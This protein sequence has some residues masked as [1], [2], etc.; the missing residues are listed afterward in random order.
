MILLLLLQAGYIETNPGSENLNIERALE[1]SK[2]LII[3]GDLNEDQLNPN[4]HNLKNVLLINS[5][6]N[7]INEP[8]RQQALL[9][10]II[11]PEDLPFLDSGTIAV[12]ANISDH[13]ATYIT[14][15][16][17]YDTEG[18]FNRL[19]FLHKRA[20]FTFL[21]QKISNFDWTCLREGTLD[22]A[23]SKFNNTFLNFVNLCVP[24]KNVLI[25]PDD[26]PWYDCEIRRVSRKRDSLKRKFNKSGNHN[27]LARYKCF[28]NK[29]NNLKRHAKEQFYNNLEF[30]ISDF[31]LNDRK[32]FWKVLRHF[33]KGNSSSS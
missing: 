6:S 28:R 22:E 9:D 17:Q 25:R 3:V 18:V 31:H 21:K 32:Q 29:V 23:C 8:T 1:H 2:N 5:M 11:I 7:V 13:K 10:P 15:P 26:K 24:S 27:I 12:P 33:V 20:N 14:L 19:I 4:F 30:S 16:F